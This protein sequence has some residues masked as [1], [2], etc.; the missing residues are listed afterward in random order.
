MSKI[1]GYLR[2]STERQDISNQKL[3]ILDYARIN[4]LKIDDFIEVQ[5]LTRKRK[6]NRRTNK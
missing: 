4:D 2:T 1:I 3:E 5:V 6:K